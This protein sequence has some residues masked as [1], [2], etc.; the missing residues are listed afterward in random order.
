MSVTRCSHVKQ[1]GAFCG[2]PAMHGRKYCYFHLNIR[3][4]R[5]KASRARRQGLA[6]PVDLPFPEDLYAVQISLH[7]IARA[8]L[9]QRLDHKAA[10]LA[11]YSLQQSATLINSKLGW[12]DDDGS[13]FLREELD[14]V[15]AE[16][17]R[18]RPLPSGADIADEPG[19]DLDQLQIPSKPVS[20]VPVVS[21]LVPAT[22]TA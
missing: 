21:A 3:G 4:R 8:V 9:E 10:G 14:E 18:V 5:L 20:S 12:M 19:Q 1:N 11:L 6:A 16:S 17:D 22:K 15:Y 2:S 7:E 13:D